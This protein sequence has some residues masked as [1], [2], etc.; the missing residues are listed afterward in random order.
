MRELVERWAALGEKVSINGSP[1]YACPRV[2]MHSE[3]ERDGFAVVHGGFWHGYRVDPD[4]VSDHAHILVAVIE[5]VEARGWLWQLGRLPNAGHWARIFTR[6]ASGDPVD[7]LNCDDGDPFKVEMNDTPA[8]ALLSAY[9][10]ALDHQA[11][12]DEYGGTR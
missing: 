2:Y 4:R 9:L 1:V 12:V 8:A 11:A 6:N 7:R 3:G 5:A 10:S